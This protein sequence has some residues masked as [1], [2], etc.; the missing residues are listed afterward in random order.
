M[1]CCWFFLVIDCFHQTGVQ[2][3]IIQAIIFF[4]FYCRISFDQCFFDTQ[5]W[6]LTQLTHASVLL[7]C[8][9]SL[10]MSVADHGFKQCLGIY[11]H[12][13]AHITRSWRWL[14]L[15]LIVWLSRVAH[16]PWGLKSLFSFST[17]FGA[18]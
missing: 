17:G 4:C 9:G 2:F 8:S 12:D 1:D 5:K 16:F 18:F 6:S 10:L 14:S 13:D 15:Y 7:S 3:G 11:G